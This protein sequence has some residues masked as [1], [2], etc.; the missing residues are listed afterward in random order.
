M[1]ENNLTSIV[2]PVRY[3]TDLDKPVLS[4]LDKFACYQI[5]GEDA[6]DFLQGQFS[7]DIAQVSDSNAQLS[8]YSTPKGRM[9]AIFYVAK[10]SG[11][12]LLI[13]S[14]DIAE[15]VIKRLQM[16]VMRSK[17]I[18]TKLDETHILGLSGDTQLRVSQ[19][20]KLTLAENDY[21]TSSSNDSLCIK[22]PG[23]P[24]RFLFLADQL[25][26]DKVKQMDPQEVYIY[27]HDYWQWLDILAGIPMVTAAT[28]EAFVPQMTNMELINGVSFSKGCYPGQ[29]VVARLHYLGNANRRMFRIESSSESNLQA[30]DSI[31]S[32]DDN[33][34]IGKL[35]T[36]VNISESKNEGLAVLRIEAAENSLP[37][38]T[39]HGNEVKIIPLPYDV[40]TE[41][42]KKDK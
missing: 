6:A 8:S 26:L 24:N 40:P 11:D 30:G 5:S 9:L 20:L 17:V 16:Y 36:T 33:K 3:A 39:K 35:I 25:L 38:K 27:S 31:Y 18:I 23:S 21:Q 41:P 28:Q 1:T 34:E 2:T 14:S 19:H 7:N 22:V 4:I 32:S 29:E 12:Y 13:T 37:L 15:E 10:R 42:K